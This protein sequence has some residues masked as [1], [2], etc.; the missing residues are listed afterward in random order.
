MENIFS[1]NLAI[2]NQNMA[3][4]VIFEEEKY[5]FITEVDTSEWKTFSFK[6][7]HDAWIDQDSLPPEIKK[8]AEDALENYLLSQH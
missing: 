6:R 8:Q 4:R 2:N 3:Y 7:E 1:T 5:T